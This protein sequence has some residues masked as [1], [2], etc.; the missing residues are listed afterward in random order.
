MEPFY[1]KSYD[2]TI[3]IAHDI[4][5]LEYGIANLDQEA[6]KYHLKE[7]HIVN[8]LNYIGEKGL[9]EMLKGVTDPKEAIS[10]IKEYEVLKNSIY[11]LPTKSNK[12]SSKK[13]YY[14]FNY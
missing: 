14:K 12:H 7:G 2:K 3:G 10:R 11:K 5:E 13:K 1:F 4:K 8:W 9:A 6:V